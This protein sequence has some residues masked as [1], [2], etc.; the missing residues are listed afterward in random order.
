MAIAALEAAAAALQHQLHATRS[1]SLCVVPCTVVIASP[2]RGALAVSRAAAWCRMAPAA[3]SD[4]ATI[5]VGGVIVLVC[6]LA[7]VLM[8]VFFGSVACLVMLVAVLFLLDEE[9]SMA[10]WGFCQAVAR[11]LLRVLGAVH[12]DELWQKP[13][14]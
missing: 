10:A 12:Q 8:G 7:V 11:A 9:M 4:S 6:T 14:E 2:C 13:D 3:Q 1:S 5:V